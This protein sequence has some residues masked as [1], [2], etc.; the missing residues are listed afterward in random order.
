MRMRE[1]SQFSCSRAQRFTAMLTWSRQG[2][3]N[4]MP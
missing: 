2:A 4:V 3:H 1:N